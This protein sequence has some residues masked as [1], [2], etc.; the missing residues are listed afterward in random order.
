A[1]QDVGAIRTQAGWDIHIGGVRGTHARSGALFCVTENEDST[2]GMI[3][4]LIQYYR[5]TAHYLEGVHQW[6]D[7]LGIVHIREVLFEEDLRAQLLESL[8]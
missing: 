8:Q 3:K 2:A 5:E 6:I 1:L 4:G 7:R